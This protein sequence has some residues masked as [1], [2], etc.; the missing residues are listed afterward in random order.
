MKTLVGGVFGG[1]LAMVM[2]S[3]GHG[4]D[5]WQFYVAICLMLAYGMNMIIW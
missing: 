5:T 4:A 1:L 2:M 3:T